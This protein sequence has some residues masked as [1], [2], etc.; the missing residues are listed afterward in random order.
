MRPFHQIPESTLADHVA[1]T[2]PDTIAGVERLRELTGARIDT[3]QRPEEGQW[4][5]STDPALGVVWLLEV[6]GPTPGVDGHLC[7]ELHRALSAPLPLLG[8]FVSASGMLTAASL[9]GPAGHA[10]LSRRST[11][12]G[13]TRTC[14]R[15]SARTSTRWRRPSPTRGATAPLGALTPTARSTDST[16]AIRIA[17]RSHCALLRS[18]SLWTSLRRHDRPSPST[19]AARRAPCA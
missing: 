13:S 4:Y 18:A 10:C 9:K 3:A 1:W 7:A 6:I 2:V 19:S 15:H 12:T 8:A 14:G 5:F 11:T 16:G 17:T